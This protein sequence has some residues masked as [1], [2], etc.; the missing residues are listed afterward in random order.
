MTVLI[1]S[2]ASFDR[3]SASGVK[4]HDGGS[5]RH[6]PEVS[7]QS[8]LASAGLPYKRLPGHFLISRAA[9]FFAW[10]TRILNSQVL[11]DERCLNPRI[12]LI[13]ASQVSCTTSS[14]KA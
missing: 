9:R 3:S 2:T 10:L 11:K 13:T 1:C 8:V 14:A 12:P 4:S 6:S 5:E 7:K